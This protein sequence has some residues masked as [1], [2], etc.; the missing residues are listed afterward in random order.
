MLSVPSAALCSQTVHNVQH[1]AGPAP[2]YLDAVSTQAGILVDSDEDAPG[3]Y[4]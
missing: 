1:I 3:S 4:P 2:P